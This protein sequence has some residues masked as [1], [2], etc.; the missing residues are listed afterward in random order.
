[1]RAVF[2]EASRLIHQKNVDVES[3]PGLQKKIYLN[4]TSQATDSIT[5]EALAIY[6]SDASRGILESLLLAAVEVDE[7]SE[8]LSVRKEIVAFYCKVFYNISS[9]SRL[10][11]EEDIA[12]SQGTEK[13]YKQIAVSYGPEMLKW[14]LFG[15]K[16]PGLA[17]QSILEMLE[18]ELAKG[19]FKIQ[20]G[21]EY[22]N[23]DKRWMLAIYNALKEER[24][25]LVADNPDDLAFSILR[26]AYGA[27]TEE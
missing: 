1:M 2:L 13:V 9:S 22:S 6:N 5:Q 18:D 15:L 16:P 26:E 4:L 20:C 27:G 21:A 17:R 10:A 25:G 19:F 3:L 11:K 7:I 8:L 12:A 14:M 24:K 23:W